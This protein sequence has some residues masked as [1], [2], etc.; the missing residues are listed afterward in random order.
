MQDAPSSSQGPK[1]KY[2]VTPEDFHLAV[3]NAGYWAR[4]R[5]FKKMLKVVFKTKEWRGEFKEVPSPLRVDEKGNP[6]MLKVL[7]EAKPN[8]IVSLPRPPKDLEDYVTNFV[9]TYRGESEKA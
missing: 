8:G 9:L 5:L 7:N 3:N 4:R 2:E 1:S 6:V